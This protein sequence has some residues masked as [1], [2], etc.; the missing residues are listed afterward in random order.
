MNTHVELEQRL[1]VKSLQLLLRFDN[2]IVAYL[3]VANHP[4]LREIR[5]FLPG[6]SGQPR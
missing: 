4:V 6:S 3:K 2:G 1:F 5:P